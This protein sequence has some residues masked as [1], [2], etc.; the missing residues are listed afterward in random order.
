VYAYRPGA[1]RAKKEA[2]TAGSKEAD[3]W[4]DGYAYARQGAR[5]NV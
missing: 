1:S 4:L 3:T 5:G 2:G